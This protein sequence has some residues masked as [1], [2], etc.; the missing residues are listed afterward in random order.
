[1]TTLID[2]TPPSNRRPDGTFFAWDS[3]SIKSVEK[4][5]RF[6]KY[7]LIDGWASHN[8]SVHLRFG[9][10]YATALE[11]FH[12]HIA[13]GMDR[14][15]ALVEV[16][17]EALIDTWDIAGSKDGV[18]IG[19]PWNSFDT[20]KTRETL[21]RT[22][23]WYID[24]FAEE[25]LKTVI[26]PDNRPAV[27][28]SFTIAVDRDIVFCGHLDRLAEM[29]GAHYVVDQ[30]TTASTVAQYY[31]AQY[32]PD[33]QVSM[34]TFAGKAL[35]HMPIS[36]MII[37][38]AQIAV[39]F[40]RFERGFVF[41]SEDQLDEWYNETMTRIERFN[42]DLLNDYFPMNAASCNNFGGCEFRSICALPVKHRE[43]FLK[44]NFQKQPLWNPL[45]RR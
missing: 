32:S 43:Q 7:K 2:R 45:E 14:E 23:V 37:D 21:I 9:A 5:A 33:T 29:G 17:H 18:P 10:H 22:I 28:Y 6:A 34:Y 44:G 3:T 24:F 12:K 19:A 16:I 40:S 36:G 13:L 15:D 39:G 8:K 26:L 31:F 38:A 30:K 42:A 41:R 11:H 27:E 25:E 4:C 35:F 1:M 20:N